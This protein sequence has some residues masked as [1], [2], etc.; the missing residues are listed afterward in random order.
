[1]F[2]NCSLLAKP[3]DHLFVPSGKSSLTVLTF[4]RNRNCPKNMPRRFGAAMIEGGIIG[5]GDIF[6]MTI[7]IARNTAEV[8]NKAVL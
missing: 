8:A 5:L 6:S 1:M 7:R 3:Q 4:A 2:I